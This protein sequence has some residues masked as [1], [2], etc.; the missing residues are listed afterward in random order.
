MKKIQIRR[1]ILSDMKNIYLIILLFVAGVSYA[2]KPSAAATMTYVS[3]EA[4]VKKFHT[5][6]ELEKMGKLDLTTLY[7]ERVAVCTELLPY[8]ALH[9]KPGATLRE[10]G[11]PE[12][13]PNL[14]HLDKEVKNKANYLSAVKTT[15]DDIIPYAD[16]K[17]IVWAILFF[18]D[19]IRVI[20]QG[21]SKSQSNEVVD[22]T[23]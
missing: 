2:Q 16:T 6:E 5:R 11:I 23:K 21:E 9:T 3:P 19:M 18:E 20:D 4:K 17:N 22:T 12:T 15:L 7:M 10:M 1:L 13:K 14:E 8:I